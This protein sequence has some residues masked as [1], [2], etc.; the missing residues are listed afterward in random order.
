P[1]PEE[2]EAGLV[3]VL[4]AGELLA[5]TVRYRGVTGCI[6]AVDSGR[7]FL[8]EWV[9]VVPGENRPCGSRDDSSAFK[10]IAGYIFG[11]GLR[12]LVAVLGYE[13]PGQIVHEDH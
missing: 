5:Y 13:P 2:I 11:A 10:V 8:A 6:A 3:I 4:L 7:Y 1:G 12:L 9:V